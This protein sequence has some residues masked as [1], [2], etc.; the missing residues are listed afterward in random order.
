M[1]SAV[2]FALIACAT[3]CGGSPDPNV[4]QAQPLGAPAL[5]HSAAGRD[6]GGTDAA[7]RRRGGAPFLSPFYRG[8]AAG[9]PPSTVITH[10]VVARA[11]ARYANADAT[12]SAVTSRASK[13]DLK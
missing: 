2:L 9:L 6:L 7:K 8:N 13:F 4:K 1:K 12:S 3:S 5:V 10:P 11:V